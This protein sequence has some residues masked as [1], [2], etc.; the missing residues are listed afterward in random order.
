MGLGMNVYVLEAIRRS[1]RAGFRLDLEQTRLHYNE[2]GAALFLGV[3]IVAITALTL[4]PDFPLKW[5]VYIYSTYCFSVPAWFWLRPPGLS[6]PLAII[7]VPFGLLL[8][9]SLQAIMPLS[10]VHLTAFLFPIVFVFLFE[11]HTRAFT[12][13]LFGS[14]LLVT[15][16]V[17]WLRDYPWLAAYLV[18][19]FG[20]TLII[21]RVVRL[22]SQKVQRLA[23]LDGL[24]GLTNRRHWEVSV[25]QLIALSERDQRPMSVAFFDLDGFKDVNDRYGHQQGDRILQAV[26]RNLRLV[27]RDSDAVARWGGDEF[28]IAMP[29][30]DAVRAESLVKRLQAKLEE[31]RVSAG[32]VQHQPGETLTS[33]LRRA[34][35]AMYQVKQARRTASA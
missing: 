25:S 16:G 30:T 14:A 31:A 28:A 26:A 6:I 19:T 32:V 8:I 9:L 21:G 13:L 27:S 7:Q 18:V 11:F 5:L 23:N 1:L 20:S 33:L 34:D 29:N 4:I 17:L 2:L 10:M 15:A 22:A 24:T 12:A 3:G 35:K